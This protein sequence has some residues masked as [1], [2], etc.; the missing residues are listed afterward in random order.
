MYK[1]SRK[2]GSV[3]SPTKAAEKLVEYLEDH[4][5]DPDDLAASQKLFEDTVV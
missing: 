2:S 4:I 3:F 1:A 5:I